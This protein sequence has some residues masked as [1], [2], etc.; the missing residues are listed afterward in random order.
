MNRTWVRFALAALVLALAWWEWPGADALRLPW[1]SAPMIN[2][3]NAQTRANQMLAS[4]ARHSG[5]P[6]G[7]F[8]EPATVDYP[9]GWEFS[10]R[11]VPC[12]AV[13]RLRIFIHRDGRGDYGETPECHPMRG[14]GVP[15]QPV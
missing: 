6:P 1:Q 14:F 2:R 8:V 11:Y 13:A 3:A 10:W 15:P 4:Y 12:P 9:D 7:H 5:D